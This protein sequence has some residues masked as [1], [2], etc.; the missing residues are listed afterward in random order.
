MATMAGRAV[1]LCAFQVQHCLM[2]ISMRDTPVEVP[3]T[4]LVMY[5][6]SRGQTLPRQTQMESSPTAL[7]LCQ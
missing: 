2:L 4:T 6:R 5:P 7:E 1:R 3:C